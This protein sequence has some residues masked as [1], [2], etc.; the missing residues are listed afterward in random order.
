[1]E[2]PNLKANQVW[3]MALKGPN[4]KTTWGA[5]LQEGELVL[6]RCSPWGGHQ[7]VYPPFYPPEAFDWDNAVLDTKFDVSIRI[8][9]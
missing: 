8:C 2:K 9:E 7:E 1:M 3:R 6:G 4:T 5:F